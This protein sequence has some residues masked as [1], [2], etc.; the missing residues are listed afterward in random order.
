MKLRTVIVILLF[1]LV[2][3]AVLGAFWH[4]VWWVFIPAGLLALLAL[5][6]LTQTRHTILRNYPIFGH[7]RYAFED[8]HTQVRQYFIEGDMEG[9]PFAREQREMVYE[10][11][12][13]EGLVHPFGT[14]ENVYRAGYEWI[15]HSIV[16]R[17]PAKEEPRVKVGGSQCSKPY[18]ASHF[19][20]SAMSFGSLSANA[21]EALNR[22]ARLGGFAHDTG[23]GGIS[24][25]HLKPGG[26][27]IWE[28][29]TG[30]FG[31]RT[32]DGKFDPVQYRER[33]TLDNV[34]MVAIKLSQGAKPGGGG[35]LPAAKLT[36]EIAVA[37]GVPMG[38]D[39]DSPPYHSVFSTPREMLEWVQ[40][41][42]EL[43][44]GKPVGFKLCV[45]RQ[46]QFMGIVKAMLETKILVDFITVDGGEGGTGA[47]PQELSDFMGTPL[48]D[49]LIFAHNT[50]VGA[51]LRKEIR[52]MA[53][54]KII[55]GFDVAAKLCMGAD[56]CN[57]ARG[58]MFALGCIQARRCHTNTCPTGI[59]TQDPWRVQGLVVKDKA[60]RVANYHRNTIRHFLW[61][62]AAAGL[63]GPED[64]KPEIL[65]RRVS[66]TEIRTYREL[67]PYLETGDLLEG[68]APELYKKPWV[69][70]SAGSF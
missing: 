21:I 56:L 19:N 18:L 42:R 34:K 36:R 45:G 1:I 29:G 8:I 44:G 16:G 11:A 70:A 6:D 20:I 23:E 69:M 13:N 54:G 26:D 27:L 63:N 33:A 37:R 40:Q 62:I 25:Y 28:L 60:E 17:W 3:I 67:Y 57:S 47:A 46:D 35:I 53:S 41:L 5:Y 61:V 7:L 10:R 43:S 31:C 55:S 22:G 9:L 12:K 15:N 39:V 30:Y 4:S 58:M 59:T 14:V 48:V 65:N 32:K 52:V 66:L 24:K 50:L 2:V 68:R 51:N 49:A 64:L 38:H